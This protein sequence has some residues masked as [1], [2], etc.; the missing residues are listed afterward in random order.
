MSLQVYGNAP[1]G[2]HH[3]RYVGHSNIKYP[4]GY[5]LIIAFG[6][7]NQ[8][9]TEAIY[10]QDG[11]PLTAVIVANVPKG[12]NPKSLAYKVRKAM[13]TAEEYDPFASAFKAPGWDHFEEP[14]PDGSNRV[15]TIAV[16]RKK[17]ENG[18][19]LSL[20]SHIKQPRN[21]QWFG[22]RQP[23]DGPPYN[24][25][26]KDGT[27]KKLSDKQLAGLPAFEREVY[28]HWTMSCSHPKWTDDAGRFVPLADAEVAGL[29]RFHRP[30]YEVARVKAM[31]GQG[32]P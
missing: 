23:Y 7:C 20:V 12:D 21:G 5:R 1:S 30:Q 17:G 18:E 29:E 26:T 19:S 10:G 3:A 25:L 8:D 6:L 16:E 2:E 11:D 14:L 27:Q 24:W 22:V 28:E 31:L 4:K 9:G 32:S 15:L 13:L